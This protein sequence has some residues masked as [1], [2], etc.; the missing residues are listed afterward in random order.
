VL[1]DPRASLLAVGQRRQRARQQLRERLLVDP[2]LGHRVIQGAVP[3]GELRPQRQP[4]QRGD[5]VIGAQDRI[6]Q[7]GQR[8]GTGGEAPVQP[9]PELPQ[10]QEPG[11][12]VRDL[13]R[14]RPRHQI[15]DRKN[16]K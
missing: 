7:L 5:R 16:G 3:P 13:R 2:A 15:T 10:R 9:G 11:D 1:A 12:R 6:S 4:H 14:V 8:V